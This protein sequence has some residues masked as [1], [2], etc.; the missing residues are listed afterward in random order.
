MKLIDRL[1]TVTDR[2]GRGVQDYTDGF[3]SQDVRRL[4]GE[5]ARHAYRV[6]TR[7]RTGEPEPNNR[8]RRFLHRTKVVFLGMSYKLAPARRLL[9]AASIVMAVLGLIQVR[10]MAAGAEVNIGSSPVWF[11]GS[12][13]GL[14]F[15]LALELVDRILVRDELEVARQ[16]QRDLLPSVAPPVPGYA[17]AQSYRTANEIGGDYY[18]FIPLP[19]GRLVIVAGDASGHGMAAGLVMAIANAAIKLAVDIDPTPD[20][21]ASLVNRALCRTGDRR[22]FMSLFC[23]LL[24]PDTG[25]IR[26]VCAGHPFPLLRDPSG[27]I[28]ELGRGAFPLGIRD[29]L[30]LTMESTVL[31]PGGTLLIYSDGLPEAT[32]PAGAAFGFDRVQALLAPGG[33]PGE[34]HDR[35]L[36]ALDHHRCDAPLGDDVSLVVVGRPA[37]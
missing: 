30:P 18:D 13:A 5:D 35:L 8:V 21:V 33:A 7:D 24:D 23:A 34:I 27:A 17:F 25:S 32:G 12:V 20:R 37:G 19:D 26:Y 1:S 10:A 6:L 36:Q 4:F 11:L 15:L 9:F 16:L 29:P 14:T 28:S 22:A 3:R 2:L 31:E